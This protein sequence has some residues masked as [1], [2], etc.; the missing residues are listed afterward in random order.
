MLCTNEDLLNGGAWPC[1]YY[2]YSNIEFIYQYT[3]YDTFYDIF[4]K[5]C[6]F[7]EIFEKS[8]IS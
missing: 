7:Y 1:H 2:K 6:T 8:V 3:F 5:M 4:V